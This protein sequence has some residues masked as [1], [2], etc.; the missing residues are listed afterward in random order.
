MI[1]SVYHLESFQAA[2][3]G[4]VTQAKTRGL[5]E[6]RTLRWE[7]REDRKVGVLRAECQGGESYTV[8]EE[9]RPAEAPSC[10]FSLVL[11]ST[12]I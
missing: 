6:L 3:Q 12:C 4:C 2:A 5:P 9:Q 8:K 1:A 7:S 11:M 10:V